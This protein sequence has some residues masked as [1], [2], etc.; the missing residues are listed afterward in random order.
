[1]L[2]QHCFIMCALPHLSQTVRCGTSRQLATDTCDGGFV[3]THV[4]FPLCGESPGTREPHSKVP[5]GRGHLRGMCVLQVP[6]GL[7]DGEAQ[8]A[9]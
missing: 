2:A 4:F 9:L 7:G 5:Q 1:M 8:L 3:Q 6:L